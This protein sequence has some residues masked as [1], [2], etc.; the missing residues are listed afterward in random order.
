MQ[1]AVRPDV[2]SIRGIPPAVAVEQRTSRGGRKSTVATMTEVHH[3]LRLLFVKLGTQYCPDCD[4][5]IDA[6]P[7]EVIVGRVLREFRGQRVQLLAPLVA[8]RKGYYT[9]LAKAAARRGQAQLR[10]DGEMLPTDPWPCLLYTSDAA[11]E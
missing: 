5:P 11:D 7:A 9:E 4:I 10:V 8:G 6:Q 3:Y 1:P 2:D